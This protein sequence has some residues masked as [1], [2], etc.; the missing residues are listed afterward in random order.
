MPAQKNSSPIPVK[1]AEL[2]TAPF[3]SGVNLDKKLDPSKRHD[4]ALWFDESRRSLLVVFKGELAVFPEPAVAYWKPQDP[5]ALEIDL[6]AVAPKSQPISAAQVKN[7]PLAQQA[8]AQA[9][10]LKHPQVGDPG[11]PT[12]PHHPGLNIAKPAMTSTQGKPK[13]MSH[14][15]LKEVVK[16]E[17]EPTQ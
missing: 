2:H 16:A 7:D 10:N 5:A 14:D 4:L 1:F 6:P 9:M 15:Q 8:R 11:K 13:I 12:V 17:S 3:L